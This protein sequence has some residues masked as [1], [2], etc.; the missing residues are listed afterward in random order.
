M[1]VGPEERVCSVCG[2][3]LAL[4][5]FYSRGKDGGKRA[6][7]RDC[8]R[9][10]RGRAAAPPP[11]RRTRPAVS[12]RAPTPAL[13][14]LEV[15]G[16]ARWHQCDGSACH[17]LRA[18]LHRAGF[19]TE[20]YRVVA[21]VETVCHY[22]DGPK[23][24]EV[25]GAMIPWQRE[26]LFDLFRLRDDGHRQY[27]RALVGVAKKNNKTG[28]ASWVATYCLVDNQFRTGQIVCAAG[29]DEQADLVFGYA[30]ETCESSRL[31]K[32]LT[33]GEGRTSLRFEREI[34]VVGLKKS[35]KRLAVGGGTL[36]G[37]NLLF[38]IEDELHE[39]TTPKSQATHTVLNRGTILNPDS[40]VLMIT[41]AGYDPESIEG[42]M[43]EYGMRVAR[44]EVDDRSFLMVWYEAPE[45]CSGE[46]EG[47]GPYEGAAGAPLDYRSREGWEAANPSGGFTVT[48]ERY[49]EDLNDPA[50]TE[51]VARR[52]HLNQH[53]S[54]E[55]MWLPHPWTHWAAPLAFTFAPGRRMVASV[56]SATSVDSTAITA[57]DVE[58]AGTAARVLSRTW[59]WERPLGPDG[60][61]VEDWSTPFEEVNAHLYSMHNGTSVEGESWCREGV[62]WHCGEAFEPLGFEAIGYDPARIQHLARQW[63]LDGLPVQE[64]PQGRRM[65]QGFATWYALLVGEQFMHEGAAGDGRI[66]ERHIRGSAVRLD[67]EG[68]RRL[69]R[70]RRVGSRAPNDAAIA[71]VMAAYLITETE[72]ERDPEFA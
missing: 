69:D 17:P 6:D 38:V 11:R 63:E 58:G 16:R 61:P 52:Y 37:R 41:T 53:T 22:P 24:G 20:G 21:F 70:R 65:A 46:Y 32:A 57:W 51:A 30:K 2:R 27:R 8:Y 9:A 1:A 15:M 64:I 59:V 5:E 42:R 66:V 19:W 7:C 14:A 31:L 47:R 43:Y 4:S 36:D 12:A 45:T 3:R 72:E 49:L 29:S 60:N 44:G 48:Y 71:Q 56:D 23:I 50:M 25:V 34:Q 67:A 40:T 33:G 62:C 68:N 28:L 54:I 18:E 55:E 39:W 10:A 26:L 13:A 35:L